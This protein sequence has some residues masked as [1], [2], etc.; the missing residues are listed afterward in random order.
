MNKT[1]KIVTI[2]LW[3][4]IVISAILVV[5]LM[6]NVGDDYKT[7]STLAGWIDSNLVWSYILIILG[8]GVAI[9]AGLINMFTDKRAAKKGLMA[10][11]FLGVLALVSYLLA[12]PEIPQFVGVDKYIANNTLNASVAKLI[13]AGLFATYILFGLAVIAIVFSSV[14]RIFK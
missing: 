5:S 11:A 13:D 7:N 12:S 10:L 4:L 8:A 1:G 9:I 3:V 2:I 6:A 14:S